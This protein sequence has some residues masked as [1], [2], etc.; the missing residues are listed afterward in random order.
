MSE[1]TC[2]GGRIYICSFL[3]S[4]MDED[5]HGEA[6]AQYLRSTNFRAGLRSG[7]YLPLFFE[8]SQSFHNDRGGISRQ[9]EL[10]H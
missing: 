5:L 2:A 4:G 9:L 1:R 6:N 8:V 10:S 3:T 7:S